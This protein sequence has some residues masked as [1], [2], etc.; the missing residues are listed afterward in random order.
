MDTLSAKNATSWKKKIF[1]ISMLIGLPISTLSVII[2]TS[3]GEVSSPLPLPAFAAPDHRHK[4]GDNNNDHN[5]HKHKNSAVT[6]AKS[7]NNEAVDHLISQIQ[8]NDDKKLN[9]S[10]IR[11][12]ID[13]L[14]K[15]PPAERERNSPSAGPLNPPVEVTNSNRAGAH[16]LSNNTSTPIKIAFVRPSFTYAAYTL[17]AFYDFYKKYETVPPGTNITTDLN[18]LTVKVPAPGQQLL[19]F[20]QR[21]GDVPDGFPEKEYM[22]KLLNFVKSQVPNSSSSNVKVD[23]ITDK[24]VNDGLIF[25]NN[26]NSSTSS[27]NNNN[28]NN[29]NNNNAYNVLFLFHQ[30]YVTA[31]EYYNLKRFVQNGGTIIFND[32]NIFT[33]EVNYNPNADTVTLV[34]GHLFKYNGQSSAWPAEQEK[35]LSENREWVGSN[36]LPNPTWDNVT[37]S[38]NPFH[39]NHTEE[40]YITN[41]N[42][43]VILD[44][45]AQI[46]YAPTDQRY[47][48]L[49]SS[50]EQL[51]N[52]NNNNMQQ[53]QQVPGGGS[54]DYAQIGTH[55]HIAVYEH[56]YGKGKVI[57]LSI[58]SW[59][60]L[61][62]Q[63]FFDF[64]Q[65]EIMPRALS[66]RTESNQ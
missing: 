6:S 29:D 52:N 56:N 46:T 42:D 57:S 31:K 15:T 37:F 59:T 60:L 3:T 65:H 18:M 35:W 13:D 32:A 11:K 63:R 41:P 33:T 44:F 7:V 17:G 14:F 25:N 47:N 48:L 34:E 61:N 30:E 8:A 53:E 4:N 12:I 55:P 54:S 58:F 49:L 38:N 9:L 22:D 62:N 39:Y 43:K 19:N 27:S 64:Y 66:T 26:N 2:S 28:N 36:F 40:Q 16:P 45:G 51:N 21:L 24:E 50:K 5:N 23:D 20:G 1:A 10:S